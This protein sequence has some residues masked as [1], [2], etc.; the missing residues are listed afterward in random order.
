MIKGAIFDMD[1]TLL[2]SMSAWDGVGE[3]YLRRL[4]CEPKAD[5]NDAIKDLS[6]RQAASYSKN[7]YDIALSVDEIVDG[8]NAMVEDFYR[9]EV[10]LKPGIAEFLRVLNERGVK[11]CIATASDRSLVEAA[12]QHCGIDKYFSE[13]FTCGSVGHGK[14]EPH[15][16]RQALESLGTEKHDTVVFE[17]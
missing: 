11:M 4:G 12:I 9:N 16:Y 1:G 5:F 14:D 10:Q 8:V 13:I 17:D 2:D 6:L 7:E 3:K 15:I